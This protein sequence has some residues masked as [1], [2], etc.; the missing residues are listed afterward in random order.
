[1]RRPY[2]PLNHRKTK[3]SIT[4][5]GLI[6]INCKFENTPREYRTVLGRDKEPI[7]CLSTIMLAHRPTYAINSSMLTPIANLF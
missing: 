2:M 5:L 6:K 7:I 1:M 3:H 4:F